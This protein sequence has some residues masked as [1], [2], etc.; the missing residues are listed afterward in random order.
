MSY[1]TRI[2]SEHGVT[3]QC[4]CDLEMAIGGAY[5]LPDGRKF[6][7]DVASV[8]EILNRII[9]VVGAEVERQKFIARAMP[10]RERPEQS[11]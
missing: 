6:W 8:R 2:A 3:K 11:I 1:A 9:P 10:A 5:E 4:G 7:I